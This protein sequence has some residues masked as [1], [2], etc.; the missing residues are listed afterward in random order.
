MAVLAQFAQRRDLHSVLAA[1]DAILMRKT[2]ARCDDAPPRTIEIVIPLIL[3]S[4]IFELWLP[5]AGFLRG[6]IV[7]D[8]HD[9]WAYA[10]GAALSSVIWKL[11][12]PT[13]LK[14]P[15]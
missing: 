12:Y 1:V 10:A 15:A 13:Q 11:I 8:Y 9:I 2:G 4:W 5:N 14:S 7:S 6:K 3:W